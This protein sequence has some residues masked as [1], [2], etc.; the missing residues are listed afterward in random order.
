MNHLASYT[1]YDFYFVKFNLS[2]LFTAFIT[3][4][5]DKVIAIVLALKSAV[6]CSMQCT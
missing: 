6:V 1:L 2:L 3:Y 4:V 5:F